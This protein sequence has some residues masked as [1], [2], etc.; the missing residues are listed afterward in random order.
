VLDATVNSNSQGVRGRREYPLARTDRTRIIAIGDSYTFGEGVNDDQTFAAFLERQLEN[1]DVLNLGVHGY[2]T[3]QQWLRLQ[4][5]GLKYRPD[6]VLFGYY[7]DDISRNRLTFRD[8]RKPHFSVVNGRLVADDL[9]IPSPEAFKSSLHWRSLSYL[10]IVMTGWRERRL[11]EENVERSKRILDAMVAATRSAHARII[12][13]Y[14][15]TP[16]QVRA[17]ES[18]HPG[19]FSYECATPDV[20]CVDPT[21]AMHDTIAPYDDWKK[22]FRYHYAPELHQVIAAQVAKA[23]I[24]ARSG[25]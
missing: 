5:D 9:P 24:A 19:L 3:D 15:P 11:E 21:N 18:H 25:R 1:T 17:N 13:L 4:I 22:F 14:L 2:G 12:Q 20:I 10:N 7:E 23:V 8:Y 16:D 6:I